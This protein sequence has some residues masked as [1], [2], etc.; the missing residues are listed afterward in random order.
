MPRMKDQYSV[1]EEKKAKEHRVY[2]NNSA[3]GPFGE[4]PKHERRD[5]QNGYRLC[6]DCI[7]ENKKEKI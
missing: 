7:T 1:N 4:I 3:C 2:H 5:G 6:D